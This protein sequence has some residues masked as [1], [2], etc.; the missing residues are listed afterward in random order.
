[1]RYVV[2]VSRSNGAVIESSASYFTAEL[3]RQAYSIFVKR[4]AGK[5]R[6]VKIERRGEVIEFRRTH[7]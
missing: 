4:H 5:G 6:T 2:T 1:M 3:A 7:P